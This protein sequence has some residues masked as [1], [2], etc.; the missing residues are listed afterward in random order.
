MGAH[1]HIVEYDSKG[2]MITASPPLP[3]T[4]EDILEH[5]DILK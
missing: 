3:L 1:K 2:N 4:K 5:G